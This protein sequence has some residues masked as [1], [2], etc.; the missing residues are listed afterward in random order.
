MTLEQS[1]VFALCDD[2]VERSAAADPVMAT[3][4][5]IVGHDDEATDYSPAGHEARAQISRETLRQ[6]DNLPLESARDRLAAGHLRERLTT[7]LAWHDAGESLVELHPFATQVVIRGNVD[8]LPTETEGDWAAIAARL[9]A[10]PQML[11]GQQ[12]SFAVGL[13]AGTPVARRQVL[14]AIE[15]TAVWA[16]LQAAPPA[17]AGLLKE[18]PAGAA[19]ARLAVVADRAHAAYGEMSRWLADE[20]LPRAAAA[21]GVGRERWAVWS[22]LALGADVD[23]HEAYAWGWE[24]LHRIEDEMA[25]EARR[26]QPGAAAATAVAEARAHL[27]ATDVVR[28]AEAYRGWLQER[29]DRALDD[30]DG[31]HFVIDPRLKRVEVVLA[32]PGSAAAPYYTPPTEDLSRPGRTWWPTGDRSTFAVWDEATTVFHEGVPGHHLQL[33][34]AKVA[35]LS[36]FSRNSFVSGHGEGWALYSERL[37]DELGW[38]ATPGERLGM[39]MGSAFRAARV[40][41]DIGTHLGLPLP[42][43]EARRHGPR[44]SYDVAVEVLRDRGQGAEHMVTSEI[45]RYFGWPAQAPSYKLGERA[46]L[47]AREDARVRLGAGFDLKAW[48]TA[49][50]DLGPLGLATMSDA[51]ATWPG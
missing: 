14:A 30:L 8:M 17:H 41:I 49:A 16:G 13:G 33:G 44:W 2:H 21:D 32:P 24:E 5:G 7:T 46:W 39:L 15:Q 1:P 36:R 9:A 27:D 23:P 4:E 51:L 20:A 48:H 38:F 37:A 10:V 26:V 35:D 22:R 43:A 40:V 45:T 11:A 6:L 18:A 47:A 50:L 28:G 31:V 42:A 12:E 3:Y 29:H 25:A 34:Q 19:G